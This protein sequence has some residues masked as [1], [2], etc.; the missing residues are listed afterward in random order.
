[1]TKRGN[2]KR[3]NGMFAQPGPQAPKEIGL[4]GLRWIPRPNK[5][6]PKYWEV[7]LEWRNPKTNQRQYD[8]APNWPHA[9]KKARQI[10]KDLNDGIV[11]SDSVTVGKAMKE[12]LA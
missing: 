5:T 8:S 2:I 12:W 3:S 9:E 6:A 11:G 10:D 1:M 4:V 7:Q